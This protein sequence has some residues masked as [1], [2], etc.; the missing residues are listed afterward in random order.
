LKI[1]DW[2][3]FFYVENQDGNFKND[4]IQMVMRS[5]KLYGPYET[6]R[7]IQQR[8]E[9]ERSPCQGGL[10]DSPDGS[11][12]FVHQQGNS[13]YLGRQVVLEPVSWI[14]GWPIVGKVLPDGVGSMVWEYEKP[15]QN[16]P[17]LHPESS[18]NFSS[19]TLNPQ[20]LWNHAP[21][22][23]KWSLNKRKGF[24]RL[25]ASVPSYSGFWG[26]SNTLTQRT[27][28]ENPANA[29][30]LIDVKGMAD[31]QE[32]GLCII[33]GN[34]WMLQV[35]QKN[36]KRILRT[37]T[38]GGTLN[39]NMDLNK[40]IDSKVWLRVLTNKDTCSFQYSLDGNTF[41][42][43]SIPFTAYFSSWRAVQIGL[44]SFNELSNTGFIDVDWF[45]YEYK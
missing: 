43:I 2:Y 23:D 16:Y 27:M 8:N 29:T 17:I 6:H 26:A 14:D 31:G 37:K 25:E 10:V 35:Y 7:M 38:Q 13:N 12:W 3:Y 41:E 5:K 34:V 19:K 45:K 11:W 4:R 15:I 20:W 44:F 28:G 24:L 22:I 30:V 21:R 36:G 32:A 9:E 39:F 40:N 33:G 42:N 1:K 18:D